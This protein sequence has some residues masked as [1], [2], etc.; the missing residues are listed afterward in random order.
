MIFGSPDIMPSASVTSTIWSAF[1]ASAKMNAVVSLPPLPKVV[2]LPSLVLPTNPAMTGIVPFSTIGRMHSLMF[3][4]H[5][6]RI[7]LAFWKASSV[8]MGHLL[9]IGSK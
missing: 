6:L 9:S 3:F 5:S 4:S 2:I 1:N 8:I 7:G